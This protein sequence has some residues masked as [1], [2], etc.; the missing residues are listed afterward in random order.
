MVIYTV[1]RQNFT[2]NMVVGRQKRKNGTKTIKSG[3][4]QQDRT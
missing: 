3:H 1:K 4:T 2:Q